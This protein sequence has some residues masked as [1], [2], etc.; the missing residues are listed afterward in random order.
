VGQRQRAVAAGDGAQLSLPVGVVGVDFEL[1]QDGFGDAVQDGCL[2]GGVPVQ[3]HRVP[4]QS[5]GEAA[6]RQRVGA[7]A[8]DDVQGGGQHHLPG[9]LAIPGSCGGG[10]GARRGRVHHR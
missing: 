3:D 4:V 2:V 7:V 5:V 6:P 1:G 9:D 10:S 8:V